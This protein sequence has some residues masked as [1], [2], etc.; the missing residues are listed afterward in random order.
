MCKAGKIRTTPNNTECS[1]PFHQDQFHKLSLHVVS[2][3]TKASDEAYHAD[4]FT[5]VEALSYRS[6]EE[7]I[8]KYDMMRINKKKV[9]WY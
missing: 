1:R 8:T 9:I 3:T 6:K 4:D 5:S 2:S 7:D